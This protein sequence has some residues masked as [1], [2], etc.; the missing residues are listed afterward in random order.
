MEDLIEATG[1]A[2]KT[3]TRWVGI[4]IV[5]IL[6]NYWK[7][8]S[9]FSRDFLLSVIVVSQQSNSSAASRK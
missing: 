4:V 9:L 1:K 2:L 6:H 5:D 3:M 7:C 8:Y